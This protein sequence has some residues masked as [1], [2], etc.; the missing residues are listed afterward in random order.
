MYIYREKEIG[1]SLDRISIRFDL[2]SVYVS[3]RILSLL[4]QIDEK[5]YLF[6]CFRVLVQPKLRGNGNYYIIIYYFILRIY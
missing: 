5:I 3:K 1:G 6:A 4:T 2:K